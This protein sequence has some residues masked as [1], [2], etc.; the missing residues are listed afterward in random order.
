MRTQMRSI[1]ASSLFLAG[2]Y[3]AFMFTPKKRP[4]VCQKPALNEPRNAFTM[5]YDD[6]SVSRFMSFT[7]IFPCERVKVFITGLYW[8]KISFSNCFR[9]SSFSFF[10]GNVSWYSLVSS[11][12]ELIRFA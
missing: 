7:S 6:W 10:E 11:S 9:Y 1:T 8:L 3:P 2:S 4:K 5:L 12:V